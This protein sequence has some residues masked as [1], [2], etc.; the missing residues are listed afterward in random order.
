M[1]QDTNSWNVEEERRISSLMKER[2]VGTEEISSPE[3][4][5]LIGLFWIVWG[6][7]SSRTNRQDNQNV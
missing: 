4:S 7:P 1:L 6:T 3:S 2:G 5:G